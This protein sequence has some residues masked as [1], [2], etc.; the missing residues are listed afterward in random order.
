MRK[1]IDLFTKI[2]G[3]LE[4]EAGL[5]TYAKI[6][7]ENGVTKQ[8]V[9]HWVKNKQI[10]FQEAQRYGTIGVERMLMDLSVAETAERAKKDSTV[11]PDQKTEDSD[12]AIIKSLQEENNFLKNKLLYFEQL[13]EAYG[14][15][16]SKVNKKKGI[17]PS[18]SVS[19]QEPEA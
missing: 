4:Y 5:K 10:L 17:R 3:I 16:A 8:A 1:R 14:I 19:N 6:G 11:K 18:E 15:D 9:I 12:A 13:M 2:R 7:A